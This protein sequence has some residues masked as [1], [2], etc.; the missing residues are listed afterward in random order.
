MQ[1]AEERTKRKLD[2]LERSF[3]LE[4]QNI[5]DEEL[6]AKNNAD[7][8]TLDSKLDELNRS[9]FESN[10]EEEPENIEQKNLEKTLDVNTLK[11][12]N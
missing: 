12:K 1:Q 6:E 10:C 9:K 8:V 2:L 5:L 3:E 7:L 11:L 4:K